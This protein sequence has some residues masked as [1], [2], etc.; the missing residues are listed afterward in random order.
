MRQHTPYGRSA[1]QPASPGF[2]VRLSG[3]VRGFFAEAF[4]DLERT[5]HFV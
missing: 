3:A 4:K 1:D 5:A 2:F